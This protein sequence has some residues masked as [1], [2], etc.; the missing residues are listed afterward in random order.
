MEEEKIGNLK[1]AMEQAAEKDAVA[2]EN[3]I[4]ATNKLTLLPTVEAILA[5]SSLHETILDKLLLVTIR[6]WLEPLPDRSLPAFSIQRTLLTALQRLPITKEHLAESGI[7]KIV[8][9]YR[10]SQ[11]VEPSIRKLADALWV[12]WSRPILKK[13][14]DFHDRQVA[15]ASYD[16][17][18]A[19]PV[20]KRYA[21]EESKRTVIPRAIHSTFSVAPKVNI[22]L[23][24]VSTSSNRRGEVDTYKKLKQKLAAK[25]SKPKR[26]GGVSIQGG[27]R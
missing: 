22:N 12:E 10:N 19:M 9:F 7:G 26:E 20:L 11:R 13:S 4:P 15:T 1:S 2:I 16:P 23:P 3:K 17:T 6:Q 25:A 27:G 21:T 8:I 18:M 5:K 14:A 24:Y